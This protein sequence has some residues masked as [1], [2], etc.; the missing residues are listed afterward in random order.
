MLS[1]MPEDADSATL[2]SLLNGERALSSPLPDH[3]VSY[4][5]EASDEDD[6]TLF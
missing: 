6:I 2:S 1:T 3:I 4:D 5:T